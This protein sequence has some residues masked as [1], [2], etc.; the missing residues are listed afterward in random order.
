M[1]WKTVKDFLHIM[2]IIFFRYTIVTNYYLAFYT[3]KKL[4]LN[5]NVNGP[6]LITMVKNAETPYKDISELYIKVL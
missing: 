1:N 6:I 3:V 4:N 2:L 5:K